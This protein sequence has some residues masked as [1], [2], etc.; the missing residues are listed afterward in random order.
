MSS[1]DQAKDRRVYLEVYDTYHGERL[2]PV[3]G[4][5]LQEDFLPSGEVCFDSCDTD[6][7]RS[8]ESEI[9]TDGC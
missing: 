5:R 4:G 9:S 6:I 3:V 7:S 2:H 1:Q 8:H